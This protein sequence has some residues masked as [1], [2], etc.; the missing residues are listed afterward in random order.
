[1]ETGWTR[2][3]GSKV[4]CLEQ[5]ID[6]RMD[7]IHVKKVKLTELIPRVKC[8]NGACPSK[9]GGVVMVIRKYSQR[10]EDNSFKS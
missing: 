3:P 6:L 4:R 1:M 7:Q 2:T 10:Q 5:V 8:E 9:K